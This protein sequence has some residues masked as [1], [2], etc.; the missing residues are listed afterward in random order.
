MR[1]CKCIN[2]PDGKYHDDM[3][4]ELKIGE[5]YFYEI[6]MELEDR[7]ESNWKEI[8]YYRVLSGNYNFIIGGIESDFHNKFLDISE[9]RKQRI[10]NLLCKN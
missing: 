6:Y 7:G 10:E 8:W 1:R 4:I 2:I 3:I 9:W 5:I